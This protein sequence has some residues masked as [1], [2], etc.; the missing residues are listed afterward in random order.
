MTSIS[1][2]KTLDSSRLERL[3][4]FLEQD[5]GNLGLMAE[6]ADTALDQKQ[7]AIARVVIG[8][9][10][11]LQPEDP[12]FRLRLA[13]TALTEGN[14]EEASSI[15]ASLLQDG[16][17]DAAV[18]FNHAYALVLRH[19]YKEAAPLLE[20]LLSE[21]APY[22][23]ATGL[24]MRCLHYLGELARAVEIGLTHM[25]AHPDDSVCAGILSLLYFDMNDL[26]QAEAWAARSLASGK[27]TLD[28]LLAAGGTALGS[29]KADEAR[30]LLTRAIDLQPHSGRAWASLG[31]VDML[32]TKLDSAEQKL[33][34]AVKYMPGHLGS[35]VALG[36]TQLMLGKLNNAEVSF[37]SA[38]SLDD[39]FAETHSGLAAVAAVRG[40]MEQA[41]MHA[42][43]AR[44]LDPSS[45]SS[46]YPKLVQLYREGN[47]EDARRLIEA[48][49]RRGQA[50]AGGT[51]LEMARRMTAKKNR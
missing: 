7:T 6:L 3:Q 49:L 36:W 12:Y 13:S 40:D 39:A 1:P 27:D 11:A 15:T 42:K 4:A 16:H 10:L 48:A 38:L 28:A 50:P 19:A 21:Q 17:T 34:Q 25:E 32:D 44:R 14:P 51:L 5:P 35:W 41:D 23:N 8:K 26:V 9:A 20:Q 2:S 45:I 29:E 47:S 22:A 37:R 33:D 18:R 43:T 30:A 46:Q 31:L 24:M